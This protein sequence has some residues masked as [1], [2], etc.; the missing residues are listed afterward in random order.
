MRLARR[1]QIPVVAA[2]L[3]VLV[4]ASAGTATAA[5]GPGSGG[6]GGGGGGGD[7][8]RLQ[9]TGN[10]G[11]I[12]DMRLK[13]AGGPITLNI[14]VPSAD[15]SEVWTLTA[16]EQEYSATTG[17]R[18]GPAVSMVPSA[19]PPLAFSPAEGGFTTT[20]DVVNAA[21]FTHGWSYVATR[22]SPTPLTCRN[23]GFWTNPGGTSEGPVAANPAGRPDTAPV[24]TGA[25]EAD[26][27]TNQVALQF[28][29]EML[30]TAQGVPAVGRFL[31]TVDGVNQNVTA[32]AVT[33]DSPPLNAVVTLTLAGAVLPAGGTV[34]VQYRQPLSNAD[35]ALQDLESLKTT[36]FGPLSIPVL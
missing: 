9:S 31:V 26:Q 1:S 10:C 30:D 17:G 36:G 29:Q 22:I 14:T 24:L 33:N 2:L 18:V 35:P 21:G 7:V 5:Q 34:T 13:T 16:T 6:G 27:G 23:Q 3:G 25:T 20:A 4:A 32:V 28:D 19:M 12:L 8:A 11:D 15:A